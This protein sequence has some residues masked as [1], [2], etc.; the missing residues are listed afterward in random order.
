M[1]RSVTILK[2]DLFVY[3]TF[4]IFLTYNESCGVGGLG[5][6]GGTTST[7]IVS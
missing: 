7:S 2:F 3:I 6:E 1:S 4:E 5:G